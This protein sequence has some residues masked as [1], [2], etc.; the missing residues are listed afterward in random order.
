MTTCRHA[1]Q[2]DL[3]EHYR[4]LTWQHFLQPIGG[5]EL[6]VYLKSVILFFPVGI[7]PSYLSNTAVRA[8]F[9]RSQHRHSTVEAALD[10][11]MGMHESTLHTRTF[12]T[13]VFSVA[14]HLAQSRFGL[15]CP[16]NLMHLGQRGS[17]RPSNSC[18]RPGHDMLAFC[19]DLH[20]RSAQQEG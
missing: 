5:A 2:Q 16:R 20:L 7:R 6:H 19:P 4:L 14:L 9:V 17:R 18:S 13:V 10:M 15:L 11:D 12:Q 8:H 1:D 3:V